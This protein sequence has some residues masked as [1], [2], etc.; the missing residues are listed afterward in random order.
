MRDPNGFVIGCG[1]AV[2]IGAGFWA[3]V[4]WLVLLLA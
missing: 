4:A 1:L 2:L 3:L